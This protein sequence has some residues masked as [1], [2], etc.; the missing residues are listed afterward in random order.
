MIV[1]FDEARM[2]AVQDFRRLLWGVVAALP[3]ALAAVPAE[4]QWAFCASLQA[5]Y[6]AADKAAS[7]A[8]LDDPG[9]ISQQL[10][11]ARSAALRAGCQRFLFFGPRPGPQC[12]GLLGRVDQLE[13]SL[14]RA[15]GGFSFFGQRSPA[16]ERNRIR[17]TLLTYGCDIPQTL[18]SSY[19]TLCVRTCDGYYFPI[20]FATGRNRFKTDDAVCQSL[21]PPGNAALF[22]HRTTGEDATQMISLAGQPYANQPFA[23]LY[24]QT[25]DQ[26]CASLLGAGAGAAVAI[27]RKPATDREVAAA[28]VVPVA[29]KKG[30]KKGAPQVE[31]DAVDPEAAAN[32]QPP[33]LTP[34]AGGAVIAA[35]GTGH[36]LR[37]IGPAYYY[38]PSYFASTSGEPP[39]VAGP[40]APVL[41]VTGPPVAAEIIPNPLK[42]FGLGKK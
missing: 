21:Y 6:V 10:N 1:R 8:G 16:M 30:G 9:K 26:N 33:S 28:M 37:T 34:D 31:P 29:V 20:S 38:D 3:L 36:P 41:E 22:V 4:A 40:V 35:A 19:R 12:P 7:G 25:Y 13:R 5:D 42:F 18:S 17:D 24:R 23:F 14:A 32:E 11:A 15:G 2:A 39:K 27:N